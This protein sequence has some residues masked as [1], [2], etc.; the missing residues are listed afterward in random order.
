MGVTTNSNHVSFINLWTS[1]E[2]LITGNSANYNHTSLQNTLATCLSVRYVS[3][4][5]N[6]LRRNFIRMGVEFEDVSW[7]LYKE[8]E[9]LNLLRD[10][11]N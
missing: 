3:D 4:L 1:I 9:I 6:D 5:L 2:Y 7:E 8:I 10:E 11:K